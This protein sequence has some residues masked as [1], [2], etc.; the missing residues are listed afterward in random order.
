MRTY[1]LAYLLTAVCCL[2]G[3]L[4]CAQRAA[5]APLPPVVQ[6][7]S[8]KTPPAG[9][10]VDAPLPRQAPAPTAKVATPRSW[11]QPI[12]LLNSHIIVSDLLSI[13]PSDI[14][15]LQV[16]KEKSGP[17]QWQSFTENGL[18]NITLKAGVKPKFKTKSLAA[19]RR[20]AKAS[21][22]VSFQLNGLP[23]EDT[24]LRVATA[25]IAELDVLRSDSETII[26][27]RFAPPKPAPPLPPGS[28]RIR[29]MASR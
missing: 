19:I 3:H 10:P 17:R 15:D 22:L 12:F 7:A 5:V 20:Q 27:I 2:A 1:Q 28:I 16:Y 11:P 18:V 21:G 6:F 13:N 9:V 14:A 29:G 4:G 26:N 23:L 8:P 25:A 24:S